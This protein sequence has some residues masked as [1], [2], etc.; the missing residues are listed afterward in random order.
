MLLGVEPFF[1]KIEATFCPSSTKPPG[2]KIITAINIKPKVRCHPLPTNG[3]IIETKKSSEK[4]TN[5]TKKTKTVQEIDRE[6][7]EKKFSKS[8][9]KKK[10]N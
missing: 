9:E 8:N 2:K 5:E 3:Y 7:L 6:K 4:N 10:L 1:L